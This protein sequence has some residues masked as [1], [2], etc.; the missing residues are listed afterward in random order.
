[1]PRFEPFA[2][3][4]PLGADLDAVVAPP[5]DVIGV[6]ERAV[7]EARSD[8]N[9][10]HLELPRDRDEHDRYTEAAC[11]LRAWIADGSL[12]LDAA[13][14]FYAYEMTASLGGAMVRTRGVLGAL[15]LEAPGHGILP[16]EQTTSKDVTD[17]LSMLIT[18]RANLSPIWVL[19]PTVGLGALASG[20]TP[21]AE[22]T[23]DDGV[24]HALRRIDD[25]DSVAAICAAVAAAPVV[26]ADGHHRFEVANRYRATHLADDRDSTGTPGAG[27]IL[28]FA[29]ELADDELTVRAIHRLLDGVAEGADLPSMFARLDGVASVDRLDVSAIDDQALLALESDVARLGGMA[30]IEP[31]GVWLVTAPDADSDRLDS[32]W[33]AELAGLLTQGDAPGLQLRN[34]H[35]A[36]RVGAAVASG[37]ATAGMLLRPATVAQIAATGS[38]GDRMP[39]KTTFFWPK[40]RTGF[41]YRLLDEG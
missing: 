26:I 5:Y 22:A 16:H 24:H 19:S 29:V 1:M 23:D 11:L 3:L 15:T 12:V 17:R 14:A 7:L 41:A 2:A 28:A 33:F 21:L 18:C 36:R 37:D 32:Q 6:D 38:G 30:L 10:V 27:A 34:Q 35:D 20:G 40:P 9:A 8:H 13:P 31:G 4:R 25:A 39:A